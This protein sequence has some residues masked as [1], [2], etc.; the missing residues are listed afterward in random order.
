MRQFA[1]YSFEASLRTGSLGTEPS[2]VHAHIDG[3]LQA[4][5]TV[6]DDGQ[7]IIFRDGRVADLK[8]SRASTDLGLLAELEL[9]EPTPGG[10]FR[11]SIGV[12]ESATSIAVYVR[13][14]AASTTLTPMYVDVHCPRLI[15]DLL[16][17]P[18]P[19]SYCGTSLSSSAISALGER[20]G[21][22]FI[23]MAW[24]PSRSVPIVAV[25]DEY[26]AVLHPGIVDALA[27]DLAGL[28]IVVRLDPAASWRITTRKQ[29]DWSCYGG[30]IRLYWPSINANSSPFRHPVWTPR[31]LL[32]GVVDTEAAASRIR[33]QL[34]RR[35]LGQSAFAIAEPSL[36]GEIKHAMRR[37]EIKALQAK[38]TPDV[39]YQSLADEYFNALV[40]ANEEVEKR[41]EQIQDLKAQVSN[42][43]LALQW[44]DES[45]DSVEPESDTPP[46]TVEEAVFEAIESF[47]GTLVFGSA[48]YDGIHTLAADA[49]PPDKILSYLE[50]LSE[51]T[52]AKRNGPLGTTM[53]KWLLERGVIASGE[54]DTV[55]RSTKDRQ[56]RTWD[57][58]TGKTRLFE[59]HLKPSDATSPD[60]CVRI[61]FDYD[62]QEQKTVVGWIGTHP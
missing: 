34:R 58:G 37:E 61:Y 22:D 21:D 15:L 33:S 57:D 62:E 59:L 55:R 13:L 41:D 14:G 20:G 60:R 12:A 54:S 51:V 36:F 1:A 11:T 56:A 16:A 19:W 10:F 30:A 6:A 53:V 52:I 9:T 32:T 49:G 38:A 46:S 8:R 25:S 45:T 29:K 28:A 4:K 47:P 27:A 48:V 23:A 39:N 18:S 24:A 3:W 17:P 7:S 2:S 31:R 40:R 50:A 5:G 42:L 26:G 44:K 43:Q 35:I